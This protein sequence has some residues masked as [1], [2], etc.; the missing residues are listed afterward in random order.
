LGPL[1]SV[2][3]QVL[4]KCSF[5][6]LTETSPKHEQCTYHIF[7]FPSPTPLQIRTVRDQ[8][9]WTQAD[10]AFMVSVTTRAWQW[11]ESGK[12]IMP[13]GLWELFLIKSDMHPDYVRNK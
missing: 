4:E 9:G 13:S 5:F 7:M 6:H 12:R 1:R 2:S 11:W 10:A 8:F 3:D